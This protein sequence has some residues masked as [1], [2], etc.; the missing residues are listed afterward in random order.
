MAWSKGHEL[1]YWKKT[2]IKKGADFYKKYLVAFGVKESDETPSADIG[3]GPFG[4]MSTV[5]LFCTPYDILADEY[6]EIGVYDK[7][8]LKADLSKKL[9]INDR[10]YEYVFCTN[11]VD[12]IPEPEYGISELARI[13]KDKLFL[14]IHLRTKEQLNKAHIHS[15]GEGDIMRWVQNAGMKIG[16]INIQHDWINEEW[17]RKAAIIIAGW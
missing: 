15:V 16:Q 6:N 1:K 5:K 17:E 9:P 7:K 2:G 8:I 4:G 11:A 12:H 13:T 14:H 10:E 3:S